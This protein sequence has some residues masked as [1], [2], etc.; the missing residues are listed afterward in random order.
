M[1]AEI[2]ER[3]RRLIDARLVEGISSAE[4][5]WLEAHLAECAECGARARSTE[6]ALQFLGA[7]AVKI[8]PAVVAATQ[9]RV[10]LRARELQEKQARMRTLW[11]VGGLS[12]VC[13]AIT[14]PLLWEVIAWVGRRFELSQAVWVATF[15]ICWVAPASVV[16]G[17]IAWRHSRT[18]A[19]RSE[20]GTWER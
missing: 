6:H 7:L 15:A 16:G 2:H 19:V 9:A 1:I 17:I 8:D 4:G 5:A 3:A 20:V 18:A 10:Q 12:W 14:A 11:I 13:G